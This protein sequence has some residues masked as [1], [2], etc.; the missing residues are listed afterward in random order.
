MEKPKLWM[1][2]QTTQ[3]DF[4]QL[5]VKEKQLFARLRDISNAYQQIKFASSLAVEDM[6]IT[7][8]IAKTKAKITVFTLETGQLNPETL[9]LL[10][11][12]KNT[13]PQLDFELFYPDTQAIK[14]YEEQKGKFAFYESVALRRECCYLRKIEPLNRAL[15]SAD[16]W[17][18][19]QR[20]S[21]STT[22]TTLPF[23]EQD[24][25]RQIAKYNP[26]Y[27]WSENEVWAYILKY[28]IPYNALY[29]QGFPSI[30][31]APCTAPVKAGDDIRAGRWW[32]ENK[33]S[34]ECGLHK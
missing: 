7:D 27:D 5:E 4:V 11:V 25:S 31:C 15:A 12:L 18:T 8:V 17:L 2:P 9:A 22:R 24:E 30:G 28:Q 20:R 32:W 29:E 6:V 34:K 10:S 33:D 1:I 26:I 16:C 3:D 14:H 23:Y 13:Y 21:Q 19:G